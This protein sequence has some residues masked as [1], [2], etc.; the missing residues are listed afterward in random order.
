MDNQVQVS[1]NILN[2]LAKRVHIKQEEENEDTKEVTKD[3]FATKV[4][5]TLKECCL[6]IQSAE[7]NEGGFTYK[8]I[9]EL[10]FS[11]L[12]VEG[13]KKDSSI[14]V[15]TVLDSM[16]MSEFITT[17]GVKQMVI[18]PSKR[19]EKQMQLQ[20]QLNPLN[21]DADTCVSL[22]AHSIDVYLSMK[23]IETM[24]NF[25]NTAQS[26]LIDTLAAESKDTLKDT[27]KTRL[28]ESVNGSK[29]L[30][31]TLQLEAPNVIVSEKWDNPNGTVVVFVLGNLFCDTDIESLK[32]SKKIRLLSDS[33]ESPPLPDEH[34]E[35]ETNFYT[36]YDIKLQN[37]RAIIVHTKDWKKHVSKKLFSFL[38]LL[39]LISHFTSSLTR[40]LT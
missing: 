25:F 39:F 35:E 29:S 40:K 10:V 5:F 2:E 3:S 24:L 30:K 1:K 19:E 22:R 15:K 37:T 20:V 23:L 27:A 34:T 21:G 9:T 14:T 38:K 7:N 26:D 33:V 11:K 36:S 16:E 6:S 18:L 8:P 12:F 17:P 32:K 13:S 4:D 28:K 31:L